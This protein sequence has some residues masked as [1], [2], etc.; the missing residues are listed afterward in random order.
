MKEP[1]PLSQ[2]PELV[3]GLVAPIG[4][5]L[6]L[7]TEVLSQALKEMS[8]QA[9]HF[10]ITKLMREVPTGLSI[11]ENP[12]IQSFKDRI[13]Y[14]NE[15]RRLLGDEALAALAIS[16]I[17]SFR[18]EERKRRGAAQPDAAVPGN[19]LSADERDEEAPLPNQAYII[20]QFKR[21]EEIA[22]LRSVYGRQFILVSAYTSQEARRQRIEEAE[23]QSRGGLIPDAEAHDL[24]NQLVIQDSKEIL[25]KHGQNVRDAYPLGDVFVDATTYEKCEAMVRRFIH[26]LFGNNEITPTHDEYGMYAAK[27]ASL[28]SSDLS[29]QIGAAIFRPSGEVITLGCNEVPKAGGGTYW[30]GDPVDK[31][32]FVQGHDPNERKK[33]E[34]LVDLI[35]R[36]KKG[37]HLSSNLMSVEDPY[38][39][40]KALV[41]DQSDHSVRESKMMDLIEFGRI[42]HAEMS[43]IC[44][45]SRK[46]ISLENATLFTTTFPCHLCAKHIV[47]SG[48]KRVVYL[49]PYPKSYA[50]DLHGDSIEVD[51]AGPT[52]KVAFEEFIGVSPYRYRELFEKGKRKYSGLAQKWNM[53]E[54]RPMIEVYYPSYFKAETHVVAQINGALEAIL[55]TAKGI[56]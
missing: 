7:L 15:V 8:Y 11:A 26:L 12:Y 27:S 44:D 43:A 28:R 10:R 22:L 33:V 37:G 25:D 4:V 38:E 35:D 2:A 9:H 39:I 17:R 24:A 13:A 36:L 1:L 54:M 19:S 45:A 23:R 6:E 51:P 49:E 52:Q 30:I 50:A 46:G 41:E 21:P 14:A 3:F 56:S 32:D 18:A 16:A 42:I 34:L 31:R 48:I 5:N 55:S 53:G 47:A 40:S 29:R 20:R